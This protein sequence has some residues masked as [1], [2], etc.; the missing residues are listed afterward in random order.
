M[1]N[2]EFILTLFLAS[3]VLIGALFYYI[4]SSS[5]KPK[6]ENEG[7][8]NPTQKRYFFFLVYIAVFAIL[9]S[10]TIPKSPYYLFADKAPDKVV[11]VAAKQFMF[12][13]SEQAI[14]AKNPKSEKIVIQS[15]K[16]VEF[17]VTSLDVNHGFA[18]YNSKAELVTQTQAMPGYVNRLRWVFN[19]PGTYNILCLEFCGSAHAYMRSSFIVK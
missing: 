2:H 13:L 14:D 9:F 3:A 16:P 6:S 12:V 8:Q 4:Y 19:E 1:K 17:R 11:Y 15:G 5:L 10:I 18:I 7:I